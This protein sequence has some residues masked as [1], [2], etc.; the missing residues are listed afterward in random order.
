MLLVLFILDQRQWDPLLFMVAQAPFHA[1]AIVALGS[2]LG[3]AMSSPGRV[4]LLA[5][6]A[7]MSLAPF[8]WENTLFACNSHFHFFVLAGVLT[9]WFCWRHEALTPGWW[10]GA[11]FAFLNLFTQGGGVFPTAAVVLLMI[12]RLMVDG[13]KE[14]PRRIIGVLILFLIVLFG[15]MTTPASPAISRLGVSRDWRRLPEFCHGPAVVPGCGSS[16][17]RRW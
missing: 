6:A 3:K 4:A 8:G 5:F 2:W 9:M 10:C 13:G 1:A 16:S 7:I 12:C 14:R 11:G 15:V 17:R